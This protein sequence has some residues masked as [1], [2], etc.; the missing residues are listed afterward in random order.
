MMQA[1]IRQRSVGKRSL[2]GT[3]A[4]QKRWSVTANLLQHINT[5][6]SS[7]LRD[8]TSPPPPRESRPPQEL[9]QLV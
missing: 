4:V 2:V 6:I 8:R 9:R 1:L 7:G 3:F 5:I